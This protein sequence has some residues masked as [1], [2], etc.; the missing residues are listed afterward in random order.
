MRDRS[1][2]R[3]MVILAA[4]SVAPC[5]ARAADLSRE[6]VGR[7]KKATVFIQ[8]TRTSL[9]NGEDAHA[10]GSGFVVSPRG[11]IATCWHV[12]CPVAR[13][14]GP[15]MSAATREV[16]FATMFISGGV[17]ATMFSTPATFAGMIVIRTLDG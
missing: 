1:T 12:V 15:A 4:A 8:V 5:L 9:I 6:S 3:W 17:Q 11:Y 2:R 10:S 7:I 14:E 13:P 16:L